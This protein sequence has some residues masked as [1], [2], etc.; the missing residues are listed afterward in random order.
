MALVMNGVLEIF[1]WKDPSV[2]GIAMNVK[3]MKI[4]AP[5]VLFPRPLST[6]MI[7]IAKPI[8]I[9]LP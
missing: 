4:H 7:A 6:K 2:N 9:L 1:N 5:P 8:D 3:M